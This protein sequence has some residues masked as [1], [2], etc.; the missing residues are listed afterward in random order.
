MTVPSLRMSGSISLRNL[1]G[2]QMAQTRR[3]NGFG[4][5]VT[6]T[7]IA[8]ALAFFFLVAQPCGQS[9]F[10]LPQIANGSSDQNS[11]R[12]AFVFFSNSGTTAQVSL[13]LTDDEGN[14]FEMTLAGLGT[15]SQFQFNLGTGQ[16]RFFQSDGNGPLR[17]G[18]ACITSDRPIGASA[19][20]S[21][22]GA[23]G[24]LVTEAGVGASPQLTRFQ[25]PVDKEGD[26]DTGVALF[27]KNPTA[28]T[29]KSTL[30]DSNGVSQ[31]L[32]DISLGAGQH[33]AFFVSAVDP[34]FS[35]QG[36]LSFKASQPA[37]AISLRQDVRLGILTT[38]PVAETDRSGRLTASNAHDWWSIAVD[39]DKILLP[40]GLQEELYVFDDCR[41]LIR[42]IDTDEFRPVLPMGTEFSGGPAGLRDAAA[43]PSGGWVVLIAGSGPD[44]L[45]R[46]QPVEDPNLAGQG[47]SPSLFSVLSSG[48]GES[49]TRGDE[50]D[51]FPRV[52]IGGDTPVVLVSVNS[53]ERGV[54]VVELD[55][56]LRH[57]LAP[58]LP[59]SVRYHGIAPMPGSNS[60]YLLRSD[61][62]LEK[63]ADL[64]TPGLEPEFLGQLPVDV[65]GRDLAFN[66]EW[67]TDSPNLIAAGTDGRVYS[68]DLQSGEF[69]LL[70]V[71]SL[72]NVYGI[73]FA[74]RLGAFARDPA[75]GSLETS[76]LD[77]F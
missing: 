30:T 10:I 29:L 73:D 57:T 39:G 24:E 55:G 59:A 31:Q 37:S 21:I 42:L 70:E 33:A 62:I 28:V 75:L 65:G 53:P 51:N 52:A 14:P 50:I 34:E 71:P 36:K 74:G 6:K 49:M 25:L 15:D 63:Y 45:M 77:E 41:N 12:T 26:F 16:T 11:I 68:F 60:I 18:A 1:S 46:V 4:N 7:A 38:L 40:D 27:N 22:F 2:D 72:I 76:W 8:L 32:E 56:S 47:P 48:F 3:R 13:A 5:K 17:T 66:P 35:G 20:F 43:H 19:V 58:A 67:R 23:Q 54:A 44:S 64:G 69:R 61:G 9:Q